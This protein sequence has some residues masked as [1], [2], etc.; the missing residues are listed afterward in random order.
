[1]FGF[2]SKIM[3][4]ITISD[5]TMRRVGIACG[6]GITTLADARC[7]FREDTVRHIIGCRTLEHLQSC[8]NVIRTHIFY[9]SLPECIPTDHFAHCINHFVSTN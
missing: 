6:N 3:F 9:H 1:M 8:G 4:H 5:M 2:V 7:L